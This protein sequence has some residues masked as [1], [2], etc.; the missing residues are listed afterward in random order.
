M[1]AI[2]V[3]ASVWKVALSRTD[4]AFRMR[5]KLASLLDHY[6]VE[7]SEPIRY[8]LLTCVEQDQ[9]SAWFAHLG[10]LPVLAFKASTW[11]VAVQLAWEASRND[12]ELVMQDALT[13]SLALQ[14]QRCL[15]TLN[16]NQQAI[17]GFRRLRLIA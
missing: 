4:D 13:V 16:G 1:D 3:D 11:S 9:R 14:Y 6:L 7:I 12:L 5:V 8:E 17:A 2:L 10:S 15:F